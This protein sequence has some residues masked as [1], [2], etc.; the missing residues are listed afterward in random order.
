VPMDILQKIRQFNDFWDCLILELIKPVAMLSMAMGTV[1]V[2][3]L[4]GVAIQPWFVTSWA[5]VQAMSIDGLFFATWDR[6]F[7]AKR[8]WAMAGL[9]LV[10][11]VLAV[12]AIA[13]NAVL[14]FQVLWAIADSQ[15]A[16][17]RL[18]ISS[19]LFTVVRAMLAVTVFI[20]IAY[21][22]SRLKAAGA[23]QQ[24]SS[25]AVA[26]EERSPAT[27][28]VARRHSHKKA[29]VSVTHSPVTAAIPEQS[30]VTHS[31][32]TVAIAEQSSIAHSLE[33]IARSHEEDSSSDGY[34]ALEEAMDTRQSM[35]IIASGSQGY[36]DK[37]K[38]IWLRHM[39][40]GREIKLADIAHDAEV[41]YSTVKK[42]APSIREEVKS[43]Q[44]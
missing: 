42:W 27:V 29:T 18:G 40:E 23:T 36:R 24:K 33:D 35:A 2:F 34:V 41:G 44:Q 43:N 26:E 25:V 5:I 28:A 4:S 37:I 12:V 11:I 39:Q 30:G 10:G 17:S 8:S 16:M 1:A 7:L 15:I 9:A 38:A 6:L 32:A 14:G 22:R 3:N 13:I 20:M 19:S 21:V 31:P